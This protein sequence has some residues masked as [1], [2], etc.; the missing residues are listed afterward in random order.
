MTIRGARL[1]YV[2]AIV[3]SVSMRLTASALHREAGTQPSAP[4]AFTVSLACN[5]LS[6]HLIRKKYGRRTC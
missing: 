5:Q 2:V 3:T 1:V 4:L 6:T